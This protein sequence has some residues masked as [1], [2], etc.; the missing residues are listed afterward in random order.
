MSKAET[1]SLFLRV[2]IEM[3]H[4]QG[5][6]STISVGVQDAVERF[7][8]DEKSDVFLLGSCTSLIGPI[9]AA[10]TLAMAAPGEEFDVLCDNDD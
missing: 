3:L 5:E 8:R 9:L 6:I 1:M 4:G 10:D 2:D 7:F